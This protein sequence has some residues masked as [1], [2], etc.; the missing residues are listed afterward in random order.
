MGFVGYLFFALKCFDHLFA[1]PLFSLGYP[2]C[3]SICAIESN[4]NSDTR[5]LIAY[6]VFYSLI[7]LFEHAFMK[8]LEWLPFWPHMKLMIM[9]WLMI[10]HFGNALYFYE[11]LVQ[12][13]LS[14]VPQIVINLF[15]EWK[16][17]CLKR[18]GFPTEAAERYQKQNESEAS[19][20]LISSDESKSIENNVG[21]K[22]DK[23]VEVT[24][25]NEDVELTEK[26]EVAA[27]ERVTPIE[28]TLVQTGKTTETLT[29]MN[30]TS[31][32]TPDFTE[33]QRKISLLQHQRNMNIQRQKKCA[34][35]NGLKEEVNIKQWD[36]HGLQIN[37]TK[38]VQGT[39]SPL[40]CYICNVWCPSKDN[41]DAHLNEKKHLAR[42]QELA[43]FV[44][45]ENKDVE[46]TE[47]NEDVEVT[48]KNE[49]ATI[50]RS[51]SIENNV[52]QKEDKDV[53]VTEENEDVEVTEENEDVEVTEKNEVAAIE[54]SKSIE[55]NVGQKED[56]DVEVTKENEDVEVTEENEDVEVTE[57]NNEV[58]AIKGSKSIEDNVEQKED[59]DVE[60]TEENEDVEVT[61]ENED[62]GV[63]EK[64]EVVAIER[65]TPI[66]STLVQTGKSIET[67]TDMN[68][69]SKSTPD[70]TK[71]QK[72]WACAICK[73]TIQSETTL[74][75]HLQGKRHKANCE[76]LKAITRAKK[77]NFPT[78]TTKK[79]E[80][81]QTQ[82]KC[83][84]S[85]G[86]KEEV[87][88]KQWDVHGLQINSKKIVQDTR[89]PLSCYI[90]NL[91]C[92]NK[93]HLDGH[94]KGKKHL[95]RIR[96]LANFVEGLSSLW[97]ILYALPFVLW[98]VIR[99]LTLGSW[100]LIGFS[101][102]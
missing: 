21:Q 38:I 20:E 86:L 23:D 95:A 32:S 50:E 25:E 89:S 77:K 22:E 84:S 45:E 8:L 40:L 97:G 42:I 90:C 100:W 52:G 55:N 44:E 18:D 16:E 76:V 2:L 79:H 75:S 80:Q 70:F 27:I 58:A 15:N 1:W 17:P 99:I 53:E 31:K 47:E 41:L 81:T 64:N 91:R 46:V 65:V 82:K 34:S 26:N 72:E 28:S 63:T 66:E 11:L 73:V 36:V 9:Y 101:I 83:P 56:K 78:S 24:E 13:C 33:V 96:E 59:K 39:R 92:P 12:P 48:E 61:E 88:I 94:L 3:A 69:T 71:V 74:N 102:R 60:V 49:V 19:E 87:N 6:W 37:S 57:K 67:L 5:K 98:R 43:D 93:D 85:N 68:V 30:V 10:P 14:L 62:V 35:S 29:D 54:R 51:K 7:S 4:S